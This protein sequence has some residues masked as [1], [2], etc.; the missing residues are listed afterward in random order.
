MAGLTI[1]TKPSAEAVPYLGAKP[2]REQGSP[3]NQNEG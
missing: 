1:L 3:R 2:F